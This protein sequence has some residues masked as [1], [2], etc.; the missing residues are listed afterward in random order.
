MLVDAKNIRAF[1]HNMFSIFE[2]H[3]LMIDT[4]QAGLFG[5]YLYHTQP[6]ENH[7]T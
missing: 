7:L 2:V 4:L 1:F 3:T 5:N 6:A